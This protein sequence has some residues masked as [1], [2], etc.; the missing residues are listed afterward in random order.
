M[1]GSFMEKTTFKEICKMMKNGDK[2]AR[3]C[4]QSVFDVAL[5]VLPELICPEASLL[6]NLSSGIDLLGVKG[7]IENVGRHVRELFDK[8]CIIDF[9]SRYERAQAAQ[10]LMVFSAYFDSIRL[11]LPN[12]SREIALSKKESVALTEK[13]IAEYAAWVKVCCSKSSSQAAQEILEFPLDLPA[14]LESKDH[15]YK[16]L[17][18]FY[19]ILNKQFISFF[20]RLSF[21]EQLTEKQRDHFLAVLRSLPKKATEN[22]DKQ[23]YE[24]KTTC[25]DFKIWAEMQE[26]IGLSKQIDVGFQNMSER[27]MRYVEQFSSKG[28]QTLDNYAK[29]YESYIND[30]LVKTTEMDISSPD[31][32]VFPAKK[33][34]FVP[35]SFKALQYKKDMLLEP[36]KTWEALEER[37]EIGQFIID[38]LHHSFTG[39]LPLLILGVP[40]A[41]K[42]LLC[43]ML[44]AQ[45]LSHEYHVLIIRLRDTVADDTIAQQINDQIERDF[46]N[47]CTWEDI[48]DRSMS[49]PI[50]LVFDGYDELLQASGRA[51][52]DYVTKI[53]EFQK[54]QRITS[55]VQVKCILTSR[56]TLIDKASIARGTTIIKLSDFD[57][58]R[59]QKWTELWNDANQNYFD[60]HQ[61]AP[62][63]VGPKSKV[64]ELA[65]QPLLLLMLALY[66]TSENALKKN[67]ELTGAQL[68][69]R[70]IREFIT[71]EQLKDA[72]FSSYPAEDQKLIVNKEMHKV[73]IAAL[74]MYNRRALFIR[75]EELEKDL[76]YLL[77]DADNAKFSPGTLQKSEKL[78]GSFFFI[79]RSDSRG[80]IQRV[81]A[82]DA[83][84]EF[85]HNTF[86]EF[87]TANFIVTEL[88]Q[89]LRYIS[90]LQQMEMLGSWDLNPKRDWFTGL[91]YAPLSSRP[92]V[93]KMIR[94]WA[95]GFFS[96]QGLDK[97]S[98]VEAM[99]FLL[100]AELDRIISGYD[101]FVLNEILS[102]NGNPFEKR[103]NLVHLACYCLNILSLCSLVC[104]DGYTFPYQNRVWDK[105]ICLWRYAF[106]EEELLDFA[107]IF[108]AERNEDTCCLRYLPDEEDSSGS[109]LHIRRLARINQAIGD[110]LTGALI[111][112]VL[113]DGDT[114]TTLNALEQNNLGISTKFLWNRALR[115]LG[116]GH[117]RQRDL[118]NDLYQLGKRCTE[119][120]TIQDVFAYYLL[121]GHL[122]RYETEGKDYRYYEHAFEV[123]LHYFENMERMF[124]YH[125]RDS[126]LY[127]HLQKA[128]ISI[129]EQL[130]T[131]M[132]DWSY[133]LRICERSGLQT[134]YL[135]ALNQILKNEQ[136]GRREE[137][138]YYLEREYSSELLYYYQERVLDR[139]R[140]TEFDLSSFLEVTYR[141][142]QFDTVNQYRKLIDILFSTLQRYLEHPSH[143]LSAKQQALLI[144][145]LYLLKD[146][147][148]PFNE[149]NWLLNYLIP[150]LSINKIYSVSPDAA[151]ELCCLQEESIFFDYETMSRDL[152]W[153]VKKH[154]DNISVKF[155]RKIRTIFERL[156][157]NLEN[158]LDDAY[159]GIVN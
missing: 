57:E 23:Y 107:N 63:S 16:R 58:K 25:S 128:I 131:E 62:F 94:E 42:T 93:V 77:T 155:Y 150:E 143:K 117:Y 32:V 92:V 82:K 1:D 51:Y 120:G 99:D 122:L 103:E 119:Q 127:I 66:D 30:R 36:D 41:G 7:A 9:T 141:L 118:K 31:D 144:R 129:A 135:W 101:I 48:A 73:S 100:R 159:E 53:M 55:G 11:Y 34:I 19:E 83:A 28:T 68:Y 106:S 126:S 3:E 61:L 124:L 6:T 96:E 148:L 76:S 156:D 110:T 90:G 64:Y 97:K 88:F 4:I 52:A 130:P 78:L 149:Q 69:D 98:V 33:D 121:L 139:L 74:G 39:N 158:L 95:L 29:V 157:I 116:E 134:M 89:K 37:D 80:S 108:R 43:H 123:G 91:S 114:K 111:S 140:L 17:L 112:T 46:A 45:I 60:R 138:L 38:T 65:K 67:S 87:L 72:S 49:K 5:V 113:G 109:Q 8:E 59:I 146:R 21:W 26:H 153:I 15:Y 18:S 133:L 105:L 44:A 104:G 22:Y 40:G 13:S 70:L 152:A 154:G 20:D 71:R 86:G 102:E 2:K 84:Y 10:V 136:L 115:M 151:Y 142:L 137:K 145:C 35:Q 125:D 27:I 12:Q 24:L 50:L 132:I 47:H 79:H 56:T 54:Q 81:D 147:N 14:P 75:A 85:L